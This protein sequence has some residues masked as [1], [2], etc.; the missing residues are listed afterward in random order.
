MTIE[1]AKRER[2]ENL[3]SEILFYV[4]AKIRLTNTSS[5]LK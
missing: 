4:D 3:A 5:M 1:L 2:A